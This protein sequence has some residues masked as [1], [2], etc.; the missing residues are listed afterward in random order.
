M[1]GRVDY[2]LYPTG[3]LGTLVWHKFSQKNKGYESLP[4]NTIE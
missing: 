4:Y 3:E 2:C 1:S